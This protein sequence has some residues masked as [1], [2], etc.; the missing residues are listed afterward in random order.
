MGRAG[1]AANLYVANGAA[2]KGILLSPVMATMVTALVVGRPREA[3]IPPEF[4]SERFS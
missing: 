3:P 4:A 1:D 2:S